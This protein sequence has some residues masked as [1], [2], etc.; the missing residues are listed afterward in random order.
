M[1]I[2]NAK[3][4]VVGLRQFATGIHRH[5]LARL[6][7]WL[8]CFILLLVANRVAAGT[9]GLGNDTLTGADRPN[10]WNIK[11]NNAGK[12]NGLT[13]SSIENLTGGAG[14]DL[15]MISDGAAISGMID[16]SSGADTLDWRQSL[17]PPTISVTGTGT[18]DGS[19]GTA[20]NIGGGFDNI[21]TLL[22]PENPPYACQVTGLLAGAGSDS[23]SV[24]HSVAISGNTVLVGAPQHLEHGGSGAAYLFRRAQAGSGQWGQVRILLPSDGCPAGYFGFSVAVS[25]G[26]VVVGARDD[27]LGGNV[28]SGSAYVFEKN[29][30]GNDNWGQVMKL[31]PAGDTLGDEFGYAVA[32]LEDTVVVGAR[33]DADNGTESGSAYVFKRN[34][35]GYGLW[36]SV[37]KLLSPDGTGGG[38]FGTSVSVDGSSVVV[39]SELGFGIRGGSAHVFNCGG[40]VLDAAPPVINCP[41]NITVPCS[42]HRIVS[43][44]FLATATDACDAVPIV[45]YSSQPGSGFPVGTTTVN[46]TARDAS[47]NEFSCTFTVTRAPL[48]FTGFLP[49]I[50]GADTTGGSYANPPRRKRTRTSALLTL[51]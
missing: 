40:T 15:F 29:Q 28:A 16:G 13:F 12:L 26:T 45:T 36:A 37:K 19:A 2:N 33:R 25:G 6:L 47:G 14:D 5:S 38:Q 9:A 42:V 3:T 18:I 41:G 44:T 4:P 27:V 50:G 1:T 39:A 31:I 22:Q 8:A 11:A 24:G 35:C 46:C 34:P 20:S 30:G 23:D 21:E 32:V 51:T 17:M 48:G 7:H 49:P 10:T 43:V